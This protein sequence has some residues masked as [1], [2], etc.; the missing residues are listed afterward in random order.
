MKHEPCKS[1]ISRRDLLRGLAAGVAAA[2]LPHRSTAAPR[3]PDPTQLG[4]AIAQAIGDQDIGFN[5]RC[6]SGDGSELYRVEHNPTALYPT[7]SCFKAF[8]A[9]YYFWHTPPALWQVER[10]D[11]IHQVVVFSDNLLAGRILADVGS[12]IEVYG[13][14][15]EKFNDFLLFTMGLSQGMH[16]WRWE[17][18]PVEFDVDP[19]FE[20][21]ETR[22]TQVRGV[23]HTVDNLTTAH[24]LVT[25]YHFMQQS[26]LLS[27]PITIMTQAPTFDALHARAAAQAALNLLSIPA[28]NY[29]SPFERVGFVGYTGKDGILP[30]GDITAGNVV[31]DAGILPARH[32]TRYL[33][34]FLSVGQSEYTAVQTLRLIA[35][36]VM[37]YAA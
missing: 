12:R 24:D 31:A 18:N 27:P 23:A 6:I 25:G 33:M 15:I 9:L 1:R 8:L 11:P 3:K 36:H 19:R 5:L 7:A 14:A 20:P 30:S 29:R 10:G 13:N 16:R 22:Y 17:G 35:S 4:E 37:Q 28:K 21:S 34:S 2:A 32:T 26:A